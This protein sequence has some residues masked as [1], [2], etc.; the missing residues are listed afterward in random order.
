MYT[1]PHVATPPHRYEVHTRT[2]PDGGHTHTCLPGQR[3]PAGSG[4]R[5]PHRCPA[6]RWRSPSISSLQAHLG[7]QGPSGPTGRSCTHA[8]GPAP[9]PDAL[10]SMG[11]ALLV[12]LTAHCSHPQA[13][14][15]SQGRPG[16]QQGRPVGQVSAGPTSTIRFP[17]ADSPGWEWRRGGPPPGSR[18]RTAGMAEQGSDTECLGP[19]AQV[20]RWRWL[21][22][23]WG[24]SGSRAHTAGTGSSQPGDSHF[25]S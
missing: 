12:S 23:L 21:L 15:A 18:F 17:A 8:S 5:P 11:L 3:W 6:P 4:A 19:V 9:V 20:T 24:P 25:L 7:W 16:C 2:A 14:G 13:E 10:V 22:G 1:P